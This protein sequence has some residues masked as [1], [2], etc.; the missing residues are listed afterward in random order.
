MVKFLM[1][2]L[3]SAIL[4]VGTLVPELVMY[5][6]WGL[7]HPTTEVGRFAMAALFLIG[8]GGFCILFGLLGFAAW[9][10]VSGEFIK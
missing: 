10:S 2:L 9:V 4:L 8:G 6:L 3:V 7:V 5:F 1:W